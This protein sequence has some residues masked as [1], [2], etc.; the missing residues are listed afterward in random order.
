M[1]YRE[2]QTDYD[3]IK[4]R[5]N[6]ANSLKSHL[7]YIE[8]IL[9]DKIRKYRDNA[10]LAQERIT[11]LQRGLLGSW[12]HKQQ[13]DNEER[14][15]RHWLSKAKLEQEQLDKVPAWRQRCAEELQLAEQQ[16]AVTEPALIIA[17]QRERAKRLAS[18]P[19][20]V[21]KA[22]AAYEQRLRTQ[23]DTWKD[24]NQ[25]EQ[26]LNYELNEFLRDPQRAQQRERSRG[27]GLSR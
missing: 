26:R 17:G 1:P 22:W 20:A 3:R 18:Q 16:L 14:Q 10:A 19:E 24:I 11:G 23:L 27:K 7:D 2:L 5:I 25:R 21:R 15:R 9:P 12:R 8:G 6:E 13:I 4:K